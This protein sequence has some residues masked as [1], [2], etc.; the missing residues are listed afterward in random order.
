MFRVSRGQSGFDADN[1]DEAR[2]LLRHE[3]L[4]RSLLYPLV[5]TRLLDGYFLGCA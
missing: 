2:E 3:K 1:L 5:A 4:G